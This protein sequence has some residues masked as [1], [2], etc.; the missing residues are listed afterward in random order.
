M[1]VYIPHTDQCLVTCMILYNLT[2]HR[3]QFELLYYIYFKK[4]WEGE[5]IL[6]A[7][8]PN[9]CMK[10]YYFRKGK[11]K[12]EGRESKKREGQTEKPL[13]IEI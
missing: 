2:T 5:G 7:P 1:R 3:I 13:E 4:F 6:R 12:R 8:R 10:P 9:L 11:G